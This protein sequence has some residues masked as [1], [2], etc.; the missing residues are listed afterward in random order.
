[1]NRPYSIQSGLPTRCYFLSMKVKFRTLF[2]G[3][4]GGVMDQEQCR[5]GG[6]TIAIIFGWYE[7]SDL[8]ADADAI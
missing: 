8:D 1:M 3:G 7:P 5:L 2:L 4:D 6:A